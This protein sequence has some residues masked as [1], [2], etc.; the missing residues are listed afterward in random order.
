MGVCAGSRGQIHFNIGRKLVDIADFIKPELT[1]IDGYRYLQRNGPTGGNLADV[2]ELGALIASPDIAL[3]DVYAAR[4]VGKDPDS[5][6]YI[7][8]AIERGF[9]SAHYAHKD[10]V[11]L[12][13]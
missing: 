3:A 7:A 4:L 12:S 8:N 10:I 13:V 11:E 2:Q 6:P 5:I 9:A 1:V